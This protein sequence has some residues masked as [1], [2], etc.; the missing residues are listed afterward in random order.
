M[1]GT[2]HETSIHLPTVQ[3]PRQCSS[4][5]PSVTSQMCS[6][7]KSRETGI[8]IPHRTWQDVTV[9]PLLWPFLL[10]LPLP[11]PFSSFLPTVSCIILKILM[12][13][14][15]MTHHAL[16]SN[17]CP[18]PSSQLAGTRHWCPVHFFSLFTPRRGTG[19]EPCQRIDLL[20]SGHLTFA[21]ALQSTEGFPTSFSLLYPILHWIH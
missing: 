14:A 4:R 2:P 17:F 8:N 12:S 20:G 15:G 5:A 18:T 16:N 21:W 6:T 10:L 1:R 3:F 13:R 19:K 9:L 7:K 11:L